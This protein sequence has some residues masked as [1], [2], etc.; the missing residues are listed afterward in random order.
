MDF[1]HWENNCETMKIT[2][3]GGE[4]QGDFL[5]GMVSNSKFIAG[6]EVFTSDLFNWH[7]GLL[8]GIFIRRPMNLVELNTIIGCITRSDYNNPLFIQ[9]QSPWFT[10]E[11][12]HSAWTLDGEFGG[13]HD[14]VEARA[15]HSGIKI[16]LPKDHIL[17]EGL[18]QVY[19]GSS[20]PSRKTEDS[21][22]PEADSAVRPGLE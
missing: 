1:T 20:G 10:F 9:A 8:E 15:I 11:S 13:I 19:L 16:A 17:S 14:H 2:W 3:E 22:E 18:S 6:T 12:H 7:D 21:L 4:A 5:Y